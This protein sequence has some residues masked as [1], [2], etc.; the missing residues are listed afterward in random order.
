MISRRDFIGPILRTSAAGATSTNASNFQWL[1]HDAKF[2]ISILRLFECAKTEFMAF[3]ITNISNC[4]Y[5]DR[6]DDDT[7]CRWRYQPVSQQKQ[8]H[9]IIMTR[10]SLV[11]II[12]IERSISSVRNLY[13]L[14]PRANLLILDL[15]RANS[16]GVVDFDLR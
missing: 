3:K 6:D 10:P 9:R 5:G 14:I 16:R 7:V 4:L 15:L 8:N 2:N 1:Y 12:N 11:I 13:L